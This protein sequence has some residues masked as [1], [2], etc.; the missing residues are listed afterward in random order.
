MK[1]IEKLKEIIGAVRVPFSEYKDTYNKMCNTEEQVV[2]MNEDSQEATIIE[3]AILEA[4][5][6][7]ILTANE[8]FELLGGSITAFL[9]YGNL[10]GFIYK[11]KKGNIKISKFNVTVR[12]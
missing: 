10:L 2:D 11:D 3:N 4:A 9:S 5:E 1:D 6:K 12:I 8:A 7:G